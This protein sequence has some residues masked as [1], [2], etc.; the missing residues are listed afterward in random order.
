MM[1]LAKL[2]MAPGEFEKHLAQ[3][4]EHLRFAFELIKLQI[5]GG[6]WFL[7]EHPAGA[8]SWA[9]DFVRAVVQRPDS[10][11]VLAHQC[12]F[13][14]KG[15]D[16]LGKALVKKPTRFLTNCAGI[17]HQLNKQCTG[18]HRHANTVGNAK[19]LRGCAIYLSLIHI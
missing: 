17:A 8:S 12:R 13:G 14:Q 2:Q 16:Q 3:A 18:G 6:R 9:L 4:V 1:N 7:F 11:L 19:M 10:H 5:A 15:T